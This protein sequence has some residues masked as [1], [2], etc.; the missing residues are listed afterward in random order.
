[1]PLGHDDF[2]NPEHATTDSLI[3]ISESIDNLRIVVAISTGRICRCLSACVLSIVLV[4]AGILT[5]LTIIA[6]R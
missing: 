2:D 3:E 1:M 4:L 5:M 6:S